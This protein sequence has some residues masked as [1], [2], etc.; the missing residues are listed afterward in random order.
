MVPSP[1]SLDELQ[2][3]IAGAELLLVYISTPTCSAC[4][5]LLPK[6]EALI[7]R[8]DIGGLHVDASVLPAIAGAH[9]V[10]TAPTL[11]LFVDGRE[12][13]RWS[14]YFSLAEVDDAL[15]RLAAL[16]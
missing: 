8:H 4:E 5:A 1:K 12:A 14:R 6:V 3:R 7:H 13:R 15:D 16:R 10:F 11:L 2:A 9:S